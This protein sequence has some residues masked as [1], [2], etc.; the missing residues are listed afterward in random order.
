MSAVH[1]PIHS[2]MSARD[3]R[4]LD[5]QRIGDAA[6]ADLGARLGIHLPASLVRKQVS[7]LMRGGDASYQNLQITQASIPTPLQFLQTWLPG[8]V[9]N[10]T[11][12][13]KI[14]EVVGIDMVGSWEDAEIVQGV[15]EATGIAVEYG[16]FTNIPFA[17]WNT[18]FESRAIVRAELGLQ[19][20]LL[21]EK[22]AAAMRV[23][24]A[25]SKRQAVGV[26]LEI[27]R[28]SVG[29]FGYFNGRGR[30]FGFLNDP[31]LPAYEQVA[32]GPWSTKGMEGMVNDLRQAIQTLRTRMQDAVDMKKV[33]MRLVLP[34][35]RIDNMTVIN[36]FGISA[37]DW[38]KQ[39]YEN[40][41]IVSAP[42]M[43]LGSVTGQSVAQ[44]VFYLFV[45]EIPSEADGSTDGGKTFRQLVQT[46]Y[47]LTGVEQ[48]A[49][50]YVEDATNATA[51]VLLTRPYAVY[52]AFGI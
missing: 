6:V 35:S 17:S 18:N 37:A 32:G 44:Q 41:E 4:A 30:T 27:F 3:V 38:L 19:V 1:S 10:M 21:E 5:I 15:Q 12:G 25:D 20:G 50:G 14:D 8:F 29:F 36:N 16:D 48:R 46:K 33:R 23:S 31:N 34:T 2:S 9:H 49:K 39:N 24:T 51:G 13:R 28:N 47:M 7:I 40:V 45:E 52:R 26:G 22:R 11:A 42:E 43:S